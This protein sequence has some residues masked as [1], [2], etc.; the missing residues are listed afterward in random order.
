MFKRQRTGSVVCASCGNLVGVNDDRCYSCGRRNPGLWGFA[1]ALRALGNDMGFLPFV[2]G[3]C[4]V[5]YV[6]SLLLSGGG[7]E[8]G[9]GPMS[10]LSPSGCALLKLG[11]SG[12]VPV[13]GLDRWWSLLAAGWLHGGL[14]HIFFN[15]YWIRQL[16]PSVADLYGPGRMV[17]LYTI[18]SIAGFFATSVAG[19]YLYFLPG[20]LAGAP[21]TVG[22]S[23]PIFG[24]LGGL[25]Y[26]GRRGGSSYIHGQA[27]SLAVVMFI[28]GLIMPG[29]DNYAH[30][31]G[32]AGGWLAGR[33]LDPLKPERIDHLAIAVGCL[34]L[35]VLS[36]LASFFMPL[37]IPDCF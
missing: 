5:M 1:P 16:A 17:I 33:W 15:M 2:T 3:L 28:F 35:S 34:G 32:F 13:F 26:Y 27:K 24:L 6:L 14:L 22:A 19:N 37:G 11:A 7:L 10:F 21:L 4:V 25:V 23:A 36:I 31:G 20:P 9:G 18:G 12:A 29:V 30:A 8:L